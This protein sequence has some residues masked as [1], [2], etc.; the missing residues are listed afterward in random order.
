MWKVWIAP[1]TVVMLAAGVADGPGAGSWPAGAE[2]T[3]ERIP[4][5]VLASDQALQNHS[6]SVRAA[7]QRAVPQPAAR[8]GAAPKRRVDQPLKVTFAARQCPQYTDIMANLARNNI[9]ESL[10]DLG[11]D[12]VYTN[13]QPID[14]AIE[15]PNHPNCDPLIGWRFTWGSGIAGSQVDLLSVVSGPAGT[16]PGTKPSTPWLDR[17]G[18]RTG[19]NLAGAV[20]VTLNGTQR[21]LLSQNRL[22]VQGGDVGDPL[23]NSVFGRGTYGFGALRCSVD[24]LN[25]DNVETVNFPSGYTHVFCYYYAVT[26]PPGA[27]KIVVRK[28]VVG[29]GQDEHTFSYN[30]NVSYNPGGAFALDAAPG[31]PGSISFNRGETRPGDDPWDFTE[32]VPDGW[33]LDSL[34]CNSDTGQS[35]TA[36]SGAK[37]EVTLAEADTVTCT[38]VDRRVFAKGISLFKRTIGGVGGPFSYEVRRPSG[39]TEAVG[40]A[41]TTEEGVAVPA[42]VVTNAEAGDYILTETLPAATEAGAWTPVGMECVDADAKVSRGRMASAAGPRVEY[43]VTLSDKPVNCT[44]TNKFTPDERLRVDKLTIGGYGRADFLIRS[45]NPRMA[46]LARRNGPQRESLITAPGRNPASFTEHHLMPGRYFVTELDQQTDSGYWE[47]TSI[48]CD[49][50]SF[51]VD[52]ATASVE[53]S[54]GSPDHTCRFTDRFVPF[55]GTLAVEKLIKDPRG[56]RTGPVRIEAVCQDGN[57]ARW[58]VA[59]GQ[60]GL[61]RLPRPLA[62]SRPTTCRVT[63]TAAGARGPVKAAVS[64]RVNGGPQSAGRTVT[65]RA[66]GPETT[67]VRFV[68]RYH[69]RARMK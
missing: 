55:G 44:F 66:G 23:L 6:A 56:L 43:R 40:T 48:E 67:T 3:R 1:L 59:R 38:Y 57:R 60:S 15:E 68:D 45:A 19:K 46:A 39:T 5:N 33:E 21:N 12:S 61:I 8:Y 27:G 49:G 16:T 14:P 63:E 62:L 28:Q 32:N 58:S 69:T 13:G 24:N 54:P 4:M 9:Q 65:V 17:Q 47:L 30:G 18:N 11:K 22:W 26:P 20:T 50:Q 36:I 51:P 29:G 25:G 2:A 41:T 10:R 64:H 34:T 37:V 52:G 31:D 7:P 35:S 53:I 42:G